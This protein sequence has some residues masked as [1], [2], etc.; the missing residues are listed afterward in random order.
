M[1]KEDR[2]S[3]IAIIIFLLILIFLFR[4]VF[5]FPSMGY[6]DVCKEPT[7]TGPAQ[8]DNFQN[9]PVVELGTVPPWNPVIFGHIP[10]LITA[11][12]AGRNPWFRA[13]A[14]SML[15]IFRWTCSSASGG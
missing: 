10:P 8:V 2:D 12:V 14:W 9:G 5:L 13:S 1:K 11:G 7:G 3:I 15:S 4:F 6:D